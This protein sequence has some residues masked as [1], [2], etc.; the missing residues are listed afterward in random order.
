[1]RKLLVYLAGAVLLIALV[2]V[3]NTL[4]LRP[5]PVEPGEAS[6]IAV[7]LPRVTENLQE[8]IRLRTVS[9]EPGKPWDP[10]PF[11][12]F[13]AFIEREYP[14]L[15]GATQQAMIAG[16]TPLFTW[17]GTDPTLKPV[18][19]TAHYDVVPVVPGTEKEWR[20]PP[21]AGD[22]VDGYV[23]GRGALDDKS[24]AI[25]ILEAA[26]ALAASGFVPRRTV[27]ISL[28]HDEEVGGDSGAAG[29]T[30]YLQEQGVQLAW[31]LD[32]GSFLVRGLLPVE[33][34]VAMINVA[35]KG[36]LSMDLTARGQGGHSSMPPPKTAV[37][38]LADAL[39][40]LQADPLPGGL[41]GPAGETFD[42]IA[43]YLPFGQ[44]LVLANR[45]LF[46]GLL[47]RLMSGNPA[48]NASLRTT[49]AP[50]MLSASPKENV[51][52]IE[53][54]ARVNFRLHPRDTP[55]SVTDHVETALADHPDVAITVLRASNASAVSSSES[56][57]FLALA[58]S[59]RAVFG[60]VIVV[61]GITIGGTDSK[62][63]AKVADDAYRYLPMVLEQEDAAGFHGTNERMSIDN[64][65]KAV[66]FYT[67]LLQAQ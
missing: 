10:Q 66:Q 2:L 59:T 21:F 22:V 1:M 9:V 8:A 30:S 50:T 34:P 44:R 13:L 18:L 43:P 23:Y 40:A 64:L 52:P 61:P 24:S 14:A 60:E 17:P 20:A 51:L 36:W 37:N 15:Y 33:P 62:H 25:C 32:E 41:A 29:V 49:M 35:E 3:V 56:E 11:N 46:G 67:R 28:G 58:A 5:P 65:G 4:A 26:E 57:G 47:E 39:V 19:L 27:F 54:S 53:A 7:N 55:E 45:W 48:V 31:S 42:G 16:Y 63:Y 38:I 6:A 12:A